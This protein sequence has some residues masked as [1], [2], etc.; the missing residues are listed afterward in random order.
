M[1]EQNETVPVNHPIHERHAAFLKSISALLTMESIF[2]S[3]WQDYGT[4][5]AIERKGSG[6]EKQESIYKESRDKIEYGHAVVVLA[7]CD[8]ME[9]VGDE[10]NNQEVAGDDTFDD[11]YEQLHKAMEEI[12]KYKQVRD[13]LEKVN[14]P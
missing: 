10:A 14:Q 12:K 7:M 1:T 4:V 6:G 2:M 11:V 13:D 8:L 9:I 3:V 5:L